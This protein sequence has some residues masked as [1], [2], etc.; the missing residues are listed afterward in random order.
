ML[1]LLQAEIWCIPLAITALFLSILLSLTTALN[2]DERNRVYIMLQV[3]DYNRLANT[4]THL[5]V[6]T[7]QVM[8]SVFYFLKLFII[9]TI[10][11]L[12]NVLLFENF[13]FSK[14][15]LAYEPMSSMEARV[16][17]GTGINSF[18]L[19]ENKQSEPR[20]ET[21]IN[22]IYR[23]LRVWRL[24]TFNTVGSLRGSYMSPFNFCLGSVYFPIPC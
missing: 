21:S 23:N 15:F 24:R 17:P 2:N 7:V 3:V 8:Q 9:I 5:A 22:I 4:M 16:P 14:A 1:F 19:Q 11:F 18:G 12:Y 6:H 13:L 20:L 10:I